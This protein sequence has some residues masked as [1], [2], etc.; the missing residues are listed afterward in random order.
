MADQAGAANGGARPQLGDSGRR[1]FVL[2][3][4]ALVA[5]SATGL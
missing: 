3:T 2:G 1:R 5:G 4:A